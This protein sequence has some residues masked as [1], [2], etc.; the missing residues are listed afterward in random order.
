M[1]FDTTILIKRIDKIK[2]SFE[3]GKF[4]DALVSSLNTGNGLMQQRIFQ[5][6]NDI[7]GNTFG[8]YV[9]SKRKARLQVSKNATQNK[10][11]KAV[12]GQDLTPYQRKRAL[13]G[14]QVSRKDLEFTGGLRRA[15]ETKIENEHAAVIEFNNDEAAKIAKGQEAQ[16]AN[17]RAGRKG[18][19]KGT[20]IKIFTLNES[21][22]EEVID[23]GRELIIQ[24]L[25]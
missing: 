2:E 7:E 8:T 21:E 25:K 11:N 20:G 18:T 16:I 13:K 24:I 17:I 23:Q 4:G 3:N 6:N 5:S 14:R 19:T 1:A 15:I 9:G 12:S 22:K 10:R